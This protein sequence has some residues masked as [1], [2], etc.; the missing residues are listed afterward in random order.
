MFTIDMKRCLARDDRLQFRPA[1]E[2]LR[3]Q[4]RSGEKMLEIVQQQKRGLTQST[5]V[6]FQ[7]FLRRLISGFPHSQRLC[8]RRRDQTLVAD[9]RQRDEVN[10]TRKLVGHSLRDLQGKPRLPNSSGP[11]QRDEPRV[12]AAE[13]LAESRLFAFAS[14]ECS[15]LQ[16]QVVRA[17]LGF[18]RRRFGQ[19]VPN[20]GQVAGEIA[21]G[22]IAIFRILGQAAL[23]DPDE[24]RRSL[25]H[26]RREALRLVTKNCG[27]RFRI[28]RFPERRNPSDHLE[29]DGAK[30]EQIGTKISF[31]SARL[32]RR[33]IADCAH[34]RPLFGNHGGSCIRVLCM[35]RCRQFRQTEVQHLGRSSAADHQVLRLQV[36]MN[37]SDLVCFGKSFRYLRR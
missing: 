32:F 4:R 28:A 30:R 26:S 19:P 9:R 5:H 22:R 36:A 21:C 17:R 35:V 34:H 37:D 33:H 1:R 13:Q 24:R 3:D 8:D 11:G 6:L 15:A 18:P 2:Q 20:R 29:Q 25:R 23:H 10:T 16:R 12:L 14:D 27:Q 31:T 7:A